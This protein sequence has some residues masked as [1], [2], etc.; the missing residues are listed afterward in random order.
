MISFTELRKTLKD[1]ERFWGCYQESIEAHADETQI[2]LKKLGLIC[3]YQICYQMLFKALGRYLHEYIGATDNPN[4]GAKPILRAANEAEMLRVPVEQWFKYV[5]MRNT[6]ADVYDIRKVD[7]LIALIPTFI[8]DAIDLYQRMSEETW[9]DH[10]D[11]S[12]IAD[13]QAWH[14]ARE[15]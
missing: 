6:V 5:D 13:R 10:D 11:Q 7:D 9:A 3:A 12:G 1:L 14:H 15:T 4:L 2:E 8:E